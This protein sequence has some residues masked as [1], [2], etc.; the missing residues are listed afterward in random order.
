[1]VR[2][3]NILVPVDF[4]A[5][6]KRA[7]NY[8]VSMA[9]A[10]E[11]RLVLAHIAAY[12]SAAYDKA[13]ADLL[14]L[15]PPDCRDR[16]NFEIIVK[17]GDVQSELLGIIDEK[18][19]EL[20][21]M[22]THGRSFFERLLLGS[23]TEGMLRKL[24]VPVLTVSHPDGE[25]GIQAPGIVSLRRILYATDLG[26]GAEKGLDLSIRLARGMEASV[27]VVHVIQS[28][29]IASH[30]M[31]TAGLLPEDGDEVRRQAEDRLG[32]MITLVSDGSVP[33]STVVT[34][35][36]PYETIN[37]VAAKHLADL[38]VINVQNKGRLERAVLGKTAER[39][40][41]TAAVPVLSLPLPATYA[42]RWV[43]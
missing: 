27:M 43:A 37:A 4:S 29:D 25:K 30:A 42:S 15:I 32:R 28:L 39:V 10:L 21:V 5:A 17:A 1:M 3:H 34:D 7:V 2:I 31:E 18:T 8:G 33:I 16:L 11:T 41:R 38:I 19:I 35:G 14:Q 40:V 20:V 23:V 6:S 26:V 13:K 9:L 12:D 24:H 36:V 22:G